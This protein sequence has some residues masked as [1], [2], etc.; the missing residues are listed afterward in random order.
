[1]PRNLERK[2]SIKSGAEGLPAT[3]AQ[4]SR[5]V[6]DAYKETT[7]A[8]SRIVKEYEQQSRGIVA[9]IEMMQPAAKNV[10]PAPASPAPYPPAVPANPYEAAVT[11]DATSQTPDSLSPEEL[12]ARA[13]ETLHSIPATRPTIPQG[14]PNAA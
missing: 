3:A 4:R 12:A 8:L 13:R 14:M 6:G 9:A 2:F 11:A 5:T 10:A 7:I 1:M